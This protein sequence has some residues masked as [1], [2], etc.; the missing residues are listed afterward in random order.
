[1]LNYASA[2][3]IFLGLIVGIFVGQVEASIYI[4]A[5]S[6]GLF[7]YISLGELVPELK[8]MVREVHADGMKHAILAFILQN[9]GMLTGATILY[10]VTKY[11]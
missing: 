11:N 7:L 4:Y 9:I 5:I 6:A 10:L 1:M 8:E 3:T 2:S